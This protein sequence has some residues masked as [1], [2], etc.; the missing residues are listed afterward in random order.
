MAFVIFIWNT[1]LTIGLIFI[2][3]RFRAALI[4]GLMATN[5]TTATAYVIRTDPMRPSADP[6][7]AGMASI[8]STL[9]AICIT[10]SISVAIVGCFRLTVYILAKCRPHRG[11]QAILYLKIFNAND[12]CL[13]R[14]KDIPLDKDLVYNQV[15]TMTSYDVS[16]STLFPRVIFSWD[17][18][19]AFAFK[20]HSNAITV[21]DL[22]SISYKNALTLHSIKASRLTMFYSFVIQPNGSRFITPLLEDIRMGSRLVRREANISGEPP[23]SV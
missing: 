22:L 19:L 12:V 13:I 8:D 18:T 2:F 7:V 3:V 11:Q 5:A 17:G 10:I 14:L 4:M 1:A 9:I 16:Y 21:P 23:T 20:S 6:V 15:P